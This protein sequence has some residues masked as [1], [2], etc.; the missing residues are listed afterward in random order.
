MADPDK[1]KQLDELLD[2]VLSQYSAMEPRPG[3]ETRIMALIA[4]S[5]SARSRRVVLRWL[6]TGA[7]ATALAAIVVFGFFARPAMRTQPS[8][9]SARTQPGP[10][11][12]PAPTAKATPERIQSRHIRTAQR[13]S[14]AVRKVS[15]VEVRQPVFPTPVPLSEQEILLLRYLS[16]TP[17]QELLAQSHPDPP[18]DDGALENGTRSFS[19]DQ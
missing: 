15:R 16:R 4:E 13:T 17:R 18:P 7:A 10:S 1:E 11:V 14:A 5:G 3:L 2:S 9:N 6:W 8:P 19:R 12:S